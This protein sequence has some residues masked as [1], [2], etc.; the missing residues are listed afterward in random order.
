MPPAFLTLCDRTICYRLD[1]SLNWE[2]PVGAICVI[3]EMTNDHGPYVDDYFICF[4]TDAQTW[5]EA[6]FYAEGR[7]RRPYA[8][9]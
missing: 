9:S 6:S 8:I 4:A 5:Y 7:E 3:G 2:L 1:G